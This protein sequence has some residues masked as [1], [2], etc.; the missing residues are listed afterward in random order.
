MSGRYFGTSVPRMEDRA[1]LT[2]R[3][4]FVDDLKVADALH[5][6]M[7]RSPHAHARVG[8]ID[9]G[10]ARAL[11]GVRAVLAY[12]DL[13]Q[14]LRAQPIPLVHPNAAIKQGFLPYVLA[15]DE[16]C[17]VGEPVAVVV[18][19]SRHIAEDA[20]EL[21]EVDYTPLPAIS[22]CR[23]AVRPGA[24]LAHSGA[25]SNIA[26]R[27][28]FKF[29]DIEAAFRGA[30]V[31]VKESLFQHRGGAF[32][33]EC[34]AG[35]AQYDAMQDLYTV[36]LATQVPHQ[37]KRFYM[38]LLELAD[39]Q[40]RVIA[41][42]IGGGFGPKA[43]FYPEYALLPVFARSL[44][45][46]VKWIEDRYEN[47]VATFQERDQYWEVELALDADGKIRGLRGSFIHDGGAYLPRGL[48][49]QW[50]SSTTVPGPYVMPAFSMEMT[51]AI[52]NR[53]PT[54]AV[55]GAG[56]PQAVFVMERLMDRAAQA[57]GLDRAEIRRR[58]FVR[59]EQ[60]PY[61]VG[62]V[63]RDGKP[64][65]YDSGD[66]PACQ[67]M[68]L[69]RID[70]AGF[71]QRQEN[72]RAQGRYIGIGIGSYVEGTGLGPYEA[73]T[74]RVATTGKIF[75]YSGAAPQG[76]SH[77][78]MLAQ[79]AA[80]Q[81]GIDPNEITVVTGDTAGTALGVGTFAARTAVNAGSSAHVAATEVRRKIL[82]IAAAQM[83]V[84]EKDLELKDGYVG[85]RGVPGMRRSLREIAVVAAG[86]PGYSLPEGVSAGLEH[87]A[88]FSPAQSTYSNGSHAA[89]VEVDIETGHVRILR[90][91]AADD[92]GHVINPMVV[93]G[94]IVGGV[95]HGIGNALFEHMRYDADGQPLTT[96]F[97]DYLL[98]HA[99]DIPRVEV[100]HMESPTPLNPLGVKGAGEGGTLPAI[101]TI[102]GAVEDA[103]SP[104][105]VKIA[106]A[107]LTP[108]R[109]VELLGD[110][111]LGRT[112]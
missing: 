17:Y 43:P 54:T 55:R 31:V 61:A 66:Y 81:F 53:V 99:A 100:L 46:P 59:P 27:V 26:A 44:G 42:D 70:Y 28:P 95:A 84:A 60:M 94:Q 110:A 111:A 24:P 107:P 75:L 9:L 69:A 4:R 77:H 80:D 86:I 19:E 3:G 51:S 30:P 12:A 92:C 48:I 45:R 90:Y 20:A 67:A 102:I 22:D 98:P 5:M 79:V 76:Q 6:V 11:P 33:M 38:D 56:R 64:V 62:L 10:A 50:I 72:A 39:N 106:E 108:Q 36:H 88:T 87:T 35:L 14:S 52:T 7:V 1:L 25:A 23:D 41:P 2:G 103:L 83:E 101:A 74:V 93:H 104:F 96:H 16:V 8:D 49:V 37:T 78:T 34:R 47:F 58:N 63:Y 65:T 97:G 29:G 85:V 109:I 18:A 13:P 112:K 57:L 73:V 21:V 68:A 40:I 91:V 82:A 32:S 105:G 71:R 15:K 89:E